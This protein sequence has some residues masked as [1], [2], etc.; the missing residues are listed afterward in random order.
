MN[1]LLRLLEPDT[2]PRSWLLRHGLYWL[3]FTIGLAVVWTYW[4]N[5]FRESL[6]AVVVNCPILMPLTYLFLYVALPKLLQG[7]YGPF[8]VRVLAYLAT[9]FLIRAV[10]LFVFSDRLSQTA[11]S[12]N[13]VRILFD[14]S[15]TTLNSFVALAAALKL[16]RYLYLKERA[17]QQLAEET[18]L[19]E[20]QVLKAQV[21]PH[22]LFNTLNNIYALTLRQS[23]EAPH[24]I[25][26]LSGLLRYML[27]ECNA[28]AVLLTSE[29]QSL[30]DYIELEQIRYSHRLTIGLRIGGNT[31]GQHIAPLLLLP[32][33]ENAFK[34]GVSGQT[35]RAFVDLSLW[36]TANE[37]TFSVENS[38]NTDTLRPSGR[39]GGLGLANVRKRLAL[40][41]PDRHTLTIRPEPTRYIVE[42]TVH[43]P[44]KPALALPIGHRP[45]RRSE[46][47]TYNPVA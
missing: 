32:F 38:K 37:L 35:G 8:M 11:F 17:N 19:I 7:Q 10:Y 4:M 27:H 1:L 20:L 41:Y 46:P 16:F 26:K 44:Q 43:L 13:P 21:H 31:A 42:L 14:T 45:K 40:L 36:V 29:I 33:V 5:S 47:A 28:P 30:R 9:N 23:A 2:S 24:I 6:K 12:D 15:F 18:L 25:R 3:V 39:H 22:F 34:H